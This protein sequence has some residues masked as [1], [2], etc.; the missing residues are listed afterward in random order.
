MKPKDITKNTRCPC[1]QSKTTPRHFKDDPIGGLL[2]SGS[3]YDIT[4]TEYCC[5]SAKHPGGL[6]QE[7]CTLADYKDCEYK[8]AQ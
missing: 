2:P 1:C 3:G 4:W 8:E 6:F 7:P 5:G